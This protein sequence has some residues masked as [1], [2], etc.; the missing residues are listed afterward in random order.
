MPAN[1][2]AHL[3]HVERSA[4]AP[5]TAAFVRKSRRFGVIIAGA[6]ALRPIARRLRADDAAR[7]GIFISA[8]ITTPIA[9]SGGVPLACILQ[10]T[11]ARRIISSTFPPLSVGARGARHKYSIALH[12]DKCAMV[13]A[14]PALDLSDH[15]D[16]LGSNMLRRRAVLHQTTAAPATPTGQWFHDYIAAGRRAPR[17]SEIRAM[18]STSPRIEGGHA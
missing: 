7:P 2:V 13:A 17:I 3:L 9:D 4:A 1:A 12:R 6:S 11:S 15:T 5:A 14:I 8:A 18:A 10:V 16:V